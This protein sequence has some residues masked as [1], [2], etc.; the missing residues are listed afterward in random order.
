MLRLRGPFANIP[1]QDPAN[2]RRPIPPMPV[3]AFGGTS[4]IATNM[5]HC[6]PSCE[7]E[8]PCSCRASYPRRCVKLTR[9]DEYRETPLSVNKSAGPFSAEAHSVIRDS[10]GL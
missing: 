6:S 9:N 7:D 2:P 1:P 5:Q 3:P 4:T 8:C 10:Y